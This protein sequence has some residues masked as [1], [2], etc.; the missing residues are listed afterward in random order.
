MYIAVLQDKQTFTVHVNIT[1]TILYAYSSS[2][3][4]RQ[5]AISRP[6]ANMSS[7]ITVS[8]SV[9]LCHPSYILLVLP[10]ASLIPLVR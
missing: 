8:N 9:I 4:I 2:W 7:L 10:Q 6:V 3:P 1:C 5:T